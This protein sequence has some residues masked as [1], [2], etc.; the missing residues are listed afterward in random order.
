MTKTA[1]ISKE[2]MILLNSV[3][4]HILVKNPEKTKVTDDE[5][6]QEALKKYDDKNYKP[7]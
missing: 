1:R 4:R 3:K 6:I 7:N 2:T 5:A